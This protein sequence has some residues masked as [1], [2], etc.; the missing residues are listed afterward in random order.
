MPAV[1]DEY[2]VYLK[3]T[4]L[5]FK[6]E[7]NAFLRN[8]HIYDGSRLLQ[9]FNNLHFDGDFSAFIV[10]ANT[11]ALRSPHPVQRG[12]GLSFFIQG[13]LGSQSNRLVVTAAGAEYS[14]ARPILATVARLFDRAIGRGP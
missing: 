3:R 12:I 6:T 4:F 9:E 10:P 8:V 1:V 7:A 11:F 13:T 5:F 2:P 14:L